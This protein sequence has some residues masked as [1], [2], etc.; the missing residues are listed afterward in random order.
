MRNCGVYA[1]INLANN[2]RYI[3]SSRNI[4]NRW[5]THRIRLNTGKHH[6]EHLQRAWLKYGKDN[7]KFLF[8]LQ[9]D[10]EDRIENEQAWID[11]CHPE[12]N[13]APFALPGKG[14]SGKKRPDKS[15]WNKQHVT[16]GHTGRPHS[17]EAK[18]K[19]SLAWIERNKRGA[20]SDETKAKMSADRKGKSN[21]SPE[22]RAKISAT[23]KGHEVTAEMREKSAAKQR[24]VKFS[25]ERIRLSLEGKKRAK[26]KRET[27]CAVD[28]EIA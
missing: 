15:L 26:E 12:Y 11:E 5:E 9:C 19:M 27:S 23:L 6:N 16:K 22:A 20:F 13:M 3:G 2:H 7:F 8:L 28:T 21:L 18:A 14:N 1:I 17:D 25:P 24:G 10:P 4:L